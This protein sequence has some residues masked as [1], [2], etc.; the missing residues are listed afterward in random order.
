MVEFNPNVRTEDRTETIHRPYQK[1]LE[2]EE[3]RR[4]PRDERSIFDLFKEMADEVRLLFRQEVHLAR[5]EMTQKAKAAVRHVA[6]IAI[7]GAVA[8]AG[9][10][11]II[12]A[13]S[14]GM[15]VLLTWGGLDLATS[16]WLGPLIVGVVVAI[17]GYALLR[18]GMNRLRKDDMVPHKTT[19]SMRENA[20]WIQERV[21]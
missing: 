17:I 6:Y 16:L 11:A 7:G 12:G 8:Y 19:E 18:S 2:T 9:V 14:A 3:R 15:M 4:L 5:A 1:P 10:L 13:L 21:K 20:Q